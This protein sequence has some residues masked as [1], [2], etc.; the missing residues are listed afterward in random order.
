MEGDSTDQGMRKAPDSHEASAHVG[1]GTAQ[2]LA[3]QAVAF[4]GI[5]GGLVKNCAILFGHLSQE[6]DL[7]HVMKQACREAL[8]HKLLAGFFRDG[9][10]L[11]QRCHA[12]TVFP[13]GRPVRARR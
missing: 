9:N 4:C 3:F 10:M 13:Q 12:E 2:S 7:A 5:C 1:V 6:H 8:V 11:R